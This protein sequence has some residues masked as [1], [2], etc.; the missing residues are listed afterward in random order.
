MFL[1]AFIK[2]V[3]ARLRG[4]RNPTAR[5]S[6]FGFALTGEGASGGILNTFLSVALVGLLVGTVV[7][8]GYTVANPKEKEKF[9]EFYLLGPVGKAADYPREMVMGE[10]ASVTV[11]IVNHEGKT[12]FYRVMASIDDAQ[13]GVA[14]PVALD[15]GATWEQPVVF[16][17]DIAGS[18]QRVDFRLY[19]DDSLEAA[20]EIYLFID[21]VEK[22]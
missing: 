16:T 18:N 12:V 19:K 1:S 15:D 21:V 8:L 2:S 20:L 9:S 13:R 11:G 4:K 7:L 10:T 14:G 22:K 6:T 5:K 3:T 17:P